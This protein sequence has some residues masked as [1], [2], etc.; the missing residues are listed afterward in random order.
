[1]GS[2]SLGLVAKNLRQAFDSVAGKSQYAHFDHQVVV[3]LECTH[4]DEL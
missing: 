3:G 1:M 4:V 2:I